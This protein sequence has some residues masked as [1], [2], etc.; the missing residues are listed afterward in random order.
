MVERL[1]NC[2]MCLDVLEDKPKEMVD[3][4]KLIEGD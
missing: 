2:R 1:G 4:L 3:Q